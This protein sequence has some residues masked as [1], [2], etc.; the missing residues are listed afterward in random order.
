MTAKQ[1]VD[2]LT[3]LLRDRVGAV[4]EVDVPS[5]DSGDWFLDAKLGSRS[6]VIQYR[7]AVGFGLSSTP[8]DGIGEGPDELL[9]DEGMVVDRVLALVSRGART[10][11]QRVQLLQ[12]LRER[13]HMSQVALAERLSVR[14]PTISKIERREDVNVSTLRRYVR[15]LGGEL[16]ITADFPEGSVEIGLGSEPDAPPAPVS[17]R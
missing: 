2:R 3:E 7:P 12:E 4:V 5:R 8:S 10:E 16:H 1:R 14:Q 9:D 11:P 17:T 6:F 13:R 15:A